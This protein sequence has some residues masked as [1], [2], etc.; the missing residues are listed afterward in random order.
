[1]EQT[2][3]QEDLLIR[4]ISSSE[5]LINGDLNLLIRVVLVE[6]LMF[7]IEIGAKVVVVNE[8]TEDSHSSEEK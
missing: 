4:T 3:C 6:L 5:M 1:M 2:L 7:L 8:A